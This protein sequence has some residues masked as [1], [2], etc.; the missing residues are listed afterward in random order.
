MANGSTTTLTGPVSQQERIVILDSLRGFAILGILLM[1]IPGFSLPG[2]PYIL[3]EWD[4]IDFKTWHFVE[5]FPEGTQRAIFSML[6]G[7]GILLFIG[8]KEKRLDGMMPA[9]YFFRRQLWLIVFSL[10]DVF[11]LLWSGDILL[12]YACL[13][14]LM[15]AFRNLPSK[16][17]LIGAG[18]CLI[19][20]LARE[21]R[22]LYHDKEIIH[23]GEMIAA[24]D[25]T[26]TKL[27]LV[28][29]EQ[30]GAMED[31][32]KNSSPESRLKRREKAIE[33]VTGNYEVLYEYRTGRYLDQLV[34]YLFL[35]PWD[36]LL[37]MF[38]G[39]AFFKMGILTG[40]ATVKTYLWMCIIGLGAGLII[41][42][43][44]L[45]P[46]INAQF[47]WF[48]QTKKIPF[49]YYNVS[50]T[51]RAIG[52]LGLIMLLYKSGW[53]KWLFALLRPVGQMAFTN[54]LMQSLMCGLF[55]YGIG[56]G[57][58]GKLQ[59]HE[60]YYVVAAV[61][62]IQIIYSNIWLHYFRFG[63]MEWAWRSL[64]YWKK[65]PFRKNNS[66]TVVTETP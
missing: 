28:Q 23:R 9:D 62:I 24:I 55:F 31:M 61:W 48:E 46:I 12:D 36:V 30:L 10:I 3:N 35:E 56:F 44:R 1:N 27:T 32:K 16:K 22:D 2:D 6:F 54:Y 20:I 25:T 47:N 17:L 63:P 26:K 19:F 52:I 33:K 64:T 4:T 38:L 15:F 51:F 5:W 57:M 45:Q 59:R 34:Q 21:N 66:A 29:K 13:G 50:R 49:S 7:A 39:M 58:F 40:Q 65:Q 14:M 8:G 43:F 53:F 41:S 11:I 60:I 18:F 37:F 42:Y